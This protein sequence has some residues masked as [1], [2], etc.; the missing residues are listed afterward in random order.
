MKKNR[1][2]FAGDVNST[3]KLQHMI[4]PDMFYCNSLQVFSAKTGNWIGTVSAGQE[5]NLFPEIAQQPEPERINTN[6]N[7]LTLFA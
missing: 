7:Q 2:I 4:A 6:E 1:H 3:G 5:V